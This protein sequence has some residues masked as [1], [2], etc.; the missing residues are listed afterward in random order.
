MNKKEKNLKSQVQ[1]LIR[2]GHT[3]EAIKHILKDTVMDELVPTLNAQIDSIIADHSPYP[4]IR[5]VFQSKIISQ[6]DGRSYLLY[7]LETKSKEVIGLEMLNQVLNREAYEG[8]ITICKFE[9]NPKSSKDFYTENGKNYFNNYEPPKWLFNHFHFKASLP[10]QALPKLYKDFLLHFTNNQLESYEYVL[11]WLAT[12]LQKRNYCYLATIGNQGVGKGVF[13]QICRSLVGAKNY[14]EIPARKFLLRNFNDEA[15][16]KNFL[17]LNEILI[18]NE[19]EANKVKVL[20]EETIMIESKGKDIVEQK[21]HLNVYVSSNS[22]DSL[23]LPGDDRRFSVIDLT[24]QKLA[25][26]TPYGTPAELT[27]LLTNEENIAQ[28]ASFLMHRKVKRDMTK[29]LETQRKKD[30][31]KY[32]LTEWEEYFL[33]VYCSKNAGKKISM[34]EVK[35]HIHLTI[36]SK[37][38]ITYETMKRLSDKVVPLL[39][40]QNGKIFFELKRERDAD[41]ARR[42]YVEMPSEQPDDVLAISS[43]NT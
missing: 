14:A 10:E 29:P 30:L 33:S 34:L 17:Y 9:Y 1:Q 38:K 39:E 21:N 25:D 24:S 13:A 32:E 43:V 15:K 6:H 5:E 31:R 37:V 18:R 4:F 27:E 11:D 42:Y 19:E 2:A 3:A 16:D 23:R 12:M 22:M 8:L 7:N 41:G 26:W 28:F 40:N 35:E 36:N 20:V